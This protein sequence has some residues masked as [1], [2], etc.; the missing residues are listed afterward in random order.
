MSRTTLAGISGRI[1]VRDDCCGAF[2]IN[3]AVF[4]FDS[5]SR[6]A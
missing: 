1:I 5:A 4:D 2:S 6:A 3:Q